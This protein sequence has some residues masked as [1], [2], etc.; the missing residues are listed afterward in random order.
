M[1]S[2]NF[3]MREM[4]DTLDNSTL[5]L[6]YYVSTAEIRALPSVAKS[7]HLLLFSEVIKLKPIASS[8]SM[9]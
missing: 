5:S 4:E 1:V 9:F 6:K 7:Q 8:V 3:L 2:N